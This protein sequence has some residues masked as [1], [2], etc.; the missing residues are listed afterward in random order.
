MQVECQISPFI[1]SAFC[2]GLLAAP[3]LSHHL[4]QH[5]PGFVGRCHLTQERHTSSMDPVAGFEPKVEPEPIDSGHGG[6]VCI[7]IPVVLGY[8]AERIGVIG[9]HVLDDAG[10]GAGQRVGAGVSVIFR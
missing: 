4:H 10:G 2:G 7:L 1:R 5:L 6:F 8:Q 9:I 3:R